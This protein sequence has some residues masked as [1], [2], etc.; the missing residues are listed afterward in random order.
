MRV[1]LA[2]TLLVCCAEFTFFRIRYSVACTIA[3]NAPH[4][5]LL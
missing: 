1:F 4:N 3:R 5:R 2:I